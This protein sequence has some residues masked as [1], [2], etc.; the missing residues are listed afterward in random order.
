MPMVLQWFDFIRVHVS[1]IGGNY[2]R[3]ENREAG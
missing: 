2:T 3:N 1:Q